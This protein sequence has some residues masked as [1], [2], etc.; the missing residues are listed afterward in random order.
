MSGLPRL[1]CDAIM[2]MMRMSVLME[3]RTQKKQYSMK[4]ELLKLWSWFVL[5]WSE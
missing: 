5:S 3:L 1:E 4:C 2:I